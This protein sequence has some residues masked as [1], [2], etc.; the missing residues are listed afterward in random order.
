[1]RA[2][3]KPAR[4]LRAP[5]RRR[6]EGRIVLI[7]G[8]SGGQGLAESRLF[9]AHGASVMLCDVRDGPGR[10]LAAEL[11]R[12]NARA[13]YAHL[14][15]T[16]ERAWQRVIA[17]VRRAWGGLHIL[18]NNAGVANRSGV[19]ATSAA[20]WERVLAINL[21]GALYGMRAA[22]PAIRDSGGGAVV[23]ISSTAGLTAHFGA[24]YTA[25]KW[26]LRGLT[27]TAAAEF[28]AWNIRVNS[29]H[30]GQV[31]DTVMAASTTAGYA[32]AGARVAPLGRAARPEEVAQLVLFLASDEASYITGA[33]IAVDGGITA[34]GLITARRALQQP[35]S[36]A[37]PAA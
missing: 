25:S 31:S 36:E 24:A 6:L 9:A 19:M 27:K 12:Q 15:V 16:D 8:A 13:A 11:S 26:G 22:A 32:A 21:T 2:R 33:E 23:N 14:D 29:V 30:P 7:T 3:T 17:R 35:G 10:S 34:A 28:A 1:V 5:P 37:P 20:E 18:V 4:A